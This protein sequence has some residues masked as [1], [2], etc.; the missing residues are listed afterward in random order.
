MPRVASSKGDESPGARGTGGRLL[1]GLELGDTAHHGF[2]G[3]SAGQR[4]VGRV[5]A[6][7]QN[8]HCM[9]K[10]QEVNE[11]QRRFGDSRFS[12]RV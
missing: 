11:T 8:Q 10:G 4:E 1:A 12:R 3:N 6:A 9:Y 5:E 7:A 2:P